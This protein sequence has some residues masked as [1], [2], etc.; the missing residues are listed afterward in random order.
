MKQYKILIITAL[1]ILCAVAGFL[2]YQKYQKTSDQ[3]K[4]QEKIAFNTGFTLLDDQAGLVWS[5][6]VE[7]SSE[8]RGQFEKKVLE[9]KNSLARNSQDES[10]RL[11]DYNNLAIYQQYLGNYREAYQAYLESLKLED[12]VRVYWQNFA[13]L[14]LKMKAY[15]SAEMAYKK[16]IE[17]NKYIPES[18]TKLA[19]YYKIA[20]D[21]Q[22]VEATYKLAIEKI[23]QSMESDTLVLSDYADWLA[24]QQRY[25]DAI[26]VYEQLIIKQPGNK[27]AIERKINNL[28]NRR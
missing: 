11:A 8:A 24:G 16:A 25:E 7:L 1:L 19:D 10:Q 3:N 20:G 13:D 27:E 17:L 6:T 14:L 22:Q 26:K 18:Y 15:K 12:S 21:G 2:Y 4:E 9:I 5:E 28:K 23:E